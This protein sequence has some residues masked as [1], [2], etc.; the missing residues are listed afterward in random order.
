M[1]WFVC[2]HSV[3][4]AAH[5]RMGILEVK[6]PYLN[7]SL[8]HSYYIERTKY[9]NDSLLIYIDL[10][11]EVPAVDFE[12]FDLNGRPKPK[13]ISAQTRNACS[14]YGR[15]LFNTVIFQLFLTSNA[16]LS[17]TVLSVAVNMVALPEAKLRTNIL[18]N[19]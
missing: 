17:L 9:S 1:V 16:I 6:L 10:S 13:K 14:E 15:S 4:I 18:R 5:R 3:N 19:N 7:I 8:V 2:I 12:M 11:F